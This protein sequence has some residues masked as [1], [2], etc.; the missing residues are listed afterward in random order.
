M[1]ALP[2]G[3]FQVI[4]DLGFFFLVLY[5]SMDLQN[6]EDWEFSLAHLSDDP[7]QLFPTIN[8]QTAYTR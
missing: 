1:V 8:I 4:I 7:I 5:D 2:H 3:L 6:Y